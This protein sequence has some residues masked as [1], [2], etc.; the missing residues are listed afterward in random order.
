MSTSHQVHG[1]GPTFIIG[2]WNDVHVHG[3]FAQLGSNHGGNRDRKRE[4]PAEFGRVVHWVFHWFVIR[5]YDRFI[6]LCFIRILKFALGNGWCS[7]LQM[8]W[9]S[10]LFSW[11]VREFSSSC[12]IAKPSCKHLNHLPCKNPWCTH[13]AITTYASHDEHLVIGAA[14][15]CVHV[16]A[17]PWSPPNRRTSP[18]VTAPLSCLCLVTNPNNTTNQSINQ[19]VNQPVKLCFRCRL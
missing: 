1:W 17:T 9:H 8:F 19:P 13:G 18:L 14:G 7:N 5:R 12:H 11:K 15:K 3:T 16:T 2:F 10:S 4:R 6:Q